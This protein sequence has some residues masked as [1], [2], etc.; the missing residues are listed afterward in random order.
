ML[1]EIFPPCRGFVDEAYTGV[2]GPRKA[3]V[4]VGVVVPMRTIHIGDQRM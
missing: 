2:E 3:T 4:A 1:L